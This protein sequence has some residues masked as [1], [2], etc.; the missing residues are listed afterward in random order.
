[1]AKRLT[2][3]QED[4]VNGLAAGMTISEIAGELNCSKESVR[5][6]KNN[7][8]LQETL[9]RRR[10]DYFGELVPLAI[11]RF[12]KLLTDDETQASVVLGACKEVFEISGFKE[13]ADNT[14]NQINITVS[15]E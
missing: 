14:N 2:C 4:I 5:L 6:V 10:H 7:P 3:L 15:Y 11:K 12:K 1:V 9:K 8:E 13:S